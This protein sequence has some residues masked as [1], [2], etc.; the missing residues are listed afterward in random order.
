V[1]E[2]LTEL[3]GGQNRFQIVGN[4][5]LNE[6]T[7]AGVVEA[8]SGWMYVNDR[9]SIEVA[10]NVR[11]QVKLNGGYSKT[12]Q[13]LYAFNEDN[14][15]VQVPYKERNNEKILEHIRKNSFITVGLEKDKENKLI[16]K[17]FLSAIDAEKYIS[18]T[19]TDEMSV[20]VYGTIEYGEYNGKE[21]RDYMLNSIW[22]NE[23][24]KALEPVARV[25]QSYLVDETALPKNWKSEL[26]KDGVV[27]VYT[28]VPQYFKKF[29][30]KVVKKILPVHQ[31]LVVKADIDDK[32][33]LKR[34]EGLVEK[35]FVVNSGVLRELT[36][37]CSINEG[38]N[39]SSGSEMKASDD[40]Q[41]LIDLGLV[42][43]EDISSIVTVR[44][45]VVK[46][47]VFE[48]PYFKTVDGIIQLGID[49]DKYDISVLQT[50]EMDSD[51]EIDLKEEVAEE[52]ELAKMFS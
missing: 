49:D 42:T 31:D 47:L 21:T 41:S 18:E 23:G 40:V 45:D 26:E 46:E 19:L 28:Q 14:K 36:A 44:G 8:A 51:D 20:S 4:V 22:L 7:F 48:M 32:D 12:K 52:D 39:A 34:A 5:R 29:E 9:I 43:A 35:S 10:E 1:T 38:W 3:K 27:H 37:V 15:S 24:E 13:I 2:K 16:R 25:I 17:R 33:A 50:P 30:D 6:K 11:P